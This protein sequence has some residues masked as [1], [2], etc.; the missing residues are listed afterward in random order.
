[1]YKRSMIGTGLL[2]AALAVPGLLAAQTARNR[3]DGPAMKTR[4]QVLND[5]WLDVG[6]YAVVSGD[7]MYLGHVTGLSEATFDFPEGWET[8]G[9]VRLL[10]D[11]I[12]GF[13]HYLTEPIHAS[14]GD[15]IQLRLADDL[16]FSTFSL[17]GPAAQGRGTT[18]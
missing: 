9:D 5:G 11:P 1:M 3:T 12:G 16:R 18:P 7:P 10:A 17:R 14:M 15:V 6:V 4:V 8:G 2:V 13:G